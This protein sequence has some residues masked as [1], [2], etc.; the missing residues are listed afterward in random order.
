MSE[1]KLVG[2]GLHK[3]ASLES[4]LGRVGSCPHEG[5]V[6]ETGDGL[7]ARL[8]NKVNILNITE[9]SFSLL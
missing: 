3:E 1:S 2:E 8:I 9:A 7:H 4:E 6:V 5:M